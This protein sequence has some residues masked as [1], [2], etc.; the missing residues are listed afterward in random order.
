MGN[1]Q[2]NC[3]GRA[4]EILQ[5]GA[6]AVLTIA[7]IASLYRTHVERDSAATYRSTSRPSIDYD[8]MDRELAARSRSAATQAATQPD[9][10]SK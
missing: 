4:N 7:L 3:G 1:E 9:Q 6:I 10:L 2:N 5:W 8:E